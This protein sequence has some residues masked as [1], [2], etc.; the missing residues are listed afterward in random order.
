M[1]ILQTMGWFLENPN[2]GYYYNQ[3]SHR[4]VHTCRKS[5]PLN[6]SYNNTTRWKANKVAWATLWSIFA[7]SCGSLSQFINPLLLGQRGLELNVCC[8]P[9]RKLW[10][11]VFSSVCLSVCSWGAHRGDLITQ[12]PPPPWPCCLNSLVRGRVSHLSS[13][14]RLMAVSK[15]TLVFTYSHRSGFP[16]KNL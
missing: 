8:L 2:H 4:L 12:G 14:F 1:V 10:E 11:D 16:S 6:W 15:S 9:P 3:H 5:P 13:S 7:D